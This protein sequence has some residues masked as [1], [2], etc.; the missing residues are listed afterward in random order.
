MKILKTHWFERFARKQ[1]ISDLVL[2]DA[3]RRAEKGQI[4]ADLGGG[5]I[6]QRIAREGE[7]RRGGFRAIVIYRFEERAFFVYGFPKNDRGNISK[8]ELDGFRKLC[9][10]LNIPDS[11]LKVMI[12]NQKFIEVSEGG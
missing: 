3:V 9:G 12:E 1:N 7:G 11:Q 2:G 5:L 8:Q 10:L 6:K 4:D